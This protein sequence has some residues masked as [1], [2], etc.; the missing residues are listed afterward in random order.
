[1]V[2][3]F[4]MVHLT[5]NHQK[6]HWWLCIKQSVRGLMEWN[7][8][9][10]LPLRPADFQNCNHFAALLA[11]WVRLRH[12]ER[13]KWP[14]VRSWHLKVTLVNGNCFIL[15]NKSKKSLYN[16][17]AVHRTRDDIQCKCP[18]THLH[19]HFVNDVFR[20][21]FKSKWKSSYFDENITA[22]CS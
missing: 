22:V 18:L 4:T 15:I 5:T 2:I 3:H 14:P 17:K 10:A 19:R 12:W 8:L 11:G 6:M 9:L 7:R 13:K 16:K 20:C 1:M 21:I